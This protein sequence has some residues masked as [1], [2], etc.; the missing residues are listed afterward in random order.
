MFNQRGS[1]TKVVHLGGERE[2][3]VSQG[4]PLAEKEPETQ[5]QSAQK[6][7]SPTVAEK[8]KYIEA[9]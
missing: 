4:A 7:L 1:L 9:S 6:N 5:N 2:E 3:P 8:E